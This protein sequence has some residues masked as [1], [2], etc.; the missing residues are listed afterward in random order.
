MRRRHGRGHRW[1]ALAPGRPVGDRRAEGGVAPRRGG[2]RRQDRRRRGAACRPAAPFLRR[3][4][5]RVGA[6][7]SPQPARG[8]HDLHA[9]HRPGRAGNLPHHRRERHHRGGLHHL[10]LAPGAGRRVGHRHEG[11]GDA[12]R[13]RADHDRRADARRGGC[14]R[15]RKEPVSDPPPHRKAGDR[16]ADQRLLYLFAVLPLDHLQGAVPRRE[17]VGLLSRPAGPPV[18]EPRGDLPPALFDQH[19]PAMVAGAALPLPG[20]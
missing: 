5:R 13:D 18:R 10:W 4:H 15:V 7:G 16:G 14:R 3:R 12:A 11:A 17:P 2:R 8:R 20:A 1:P 19:L 6:Q 9:A